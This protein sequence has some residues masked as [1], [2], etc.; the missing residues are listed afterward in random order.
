[1]KKLI[2]ISIVLSLFLPCATAL[3]DE[4]QVNRYVE[5]LR[6]DIRD[7]KEEIIREALQF[8]EGEGKIAADFWNV[9]CEYQKGLAKIT[10]S[11]IAMIKEYAAEYGAM[12]Q[13][14]A[15]A[16]GKKAL[17]IEK[18][19]LKL[20]EKYFDRFAKALGP[21]GAIRFFQIETVLNNIINLKISTEL[22]LFPQRAAAK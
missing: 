21:S 8:K 5:M 17:G 13:K 15:K 7:Q 22:P 10:D 2:L 6:Q 1:M 14:K 4:A 3:A 9:Y 12:T 20:R 16:F 18:D 19:Y 11:R